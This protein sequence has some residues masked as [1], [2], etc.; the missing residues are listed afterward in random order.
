[1]V[2]M[3]A[4]TMESF[5]QTVLGENWVEITFILTLAIVAIFVIIVCNLASKIKEVNTE[6]AKL[7]DVRSEKPFK[8]FQTLFYNSSSI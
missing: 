4:M 1:M 8:V 6:L 5:F 3:L 2:N 7:K